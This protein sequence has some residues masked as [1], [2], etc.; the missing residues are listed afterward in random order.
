MRCIKTSRWRL[1]VLKANGRLLY[2]GDLR[3]KGYTELFKDL[4]CQYG[5]R[6]KAEVDVIYIKN[7]LSWPIFN[8][9]TLEQKANYLSSRIELLTR[10]CAGS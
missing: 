10:L 9:I 8:E 5:Q 6:E 2:G 3:N 7:Y 4:S 1:Q